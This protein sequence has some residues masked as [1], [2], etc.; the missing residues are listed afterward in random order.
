MDHSQFAARADDPNHPIRLHMMELI[1]LLG[2]GKRLEMLAAL[3]TG[4]LC[5]DELASVLNY[6]PTDMSKNLKV[7]RSAGLV[8]EGRDGHSHP[9]CLTTGV[10]AHLRDQHLSISTTTYRREELVISMIPDSLILQMLKDR[11]HRSRDAA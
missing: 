10:S 2:C 6:E 9:H 3:S 5:V 7:L 4:P 8:Q 1:R 11:H